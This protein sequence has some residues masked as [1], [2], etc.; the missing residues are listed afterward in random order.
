MSRG[1]LSRGS[2]ILFLEIFWVQLSGGSFPRWDYPG[3]ICPGGICLRSNYLMSEL[4]GRGAV[5]LRVIF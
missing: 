3:D 1:H 4:S 5:V 2:I